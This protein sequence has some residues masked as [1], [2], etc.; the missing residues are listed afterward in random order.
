MNSSE[1]WKKFHACLR[2]INS[3]VQMTFRGYPGALL[4]IC[5]SAI[6]R[7]GAS[8]VDAHPTCSC[9]PDVSSDIFSEYISSDT[10][11]T[12]ARASLLPDPQFRALLSRFERGSHSAPDNTVTV[13]LTGTFVES[14]LGE[15]SIADD[16]ESPSGQVQESLRGSNGATSGS[17]EPEPWSIPASD[18]ISKT[19]MGDLRQVLDDAGVGAAE[20]ADVY[21]E[22]QNRVNVALFRIH[23]E[24]DQ[25]SDCSLLVC[26]AWREVL[27]QTSLRTS[28][29]FSERS[30]TSAAQLEAELRPILYSLV[31]SPTKE[32]MEV[33]FAPIVA[34]LAPIAIQGAVQITCWC[35]RYWSRTTTTPEPTTQAPTTTPDKIGEMRSLYFLTANAYL[36]EASQLLATVR[37]EG[38]AESAVIKMISDVREKISDKIVKITTVI[39]KLTALA[40]GTIFDPSNCTRLAF[41]VIKSLNG[42]TSSS[43]W[44]QVSS[45][46]YGTIG[47]IRSELLKFA[48]V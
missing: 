2:I 24:T 5:I 45:K 27:K 35:I 48:L 8:I 15:H 19:S 1:T 34:V 39:S 14:D 20:D 3:I 36:D 28:I 25:L 12:A 42:A 47:S 37:V 18:Y 38:Q 46:V 21:G 4:L 44:Y 7:G 32:E 26:R 13:I 41:D 22:L 33:A 16:R 30:W 11:L 29:S 40:A 9:G 17:E 23:T 43:Q 10:Y 6:R 31:S